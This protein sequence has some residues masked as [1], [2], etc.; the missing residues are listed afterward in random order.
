MNRIRIRRALVRH[1]PILG[2]ALLVAACAG[3][4]GGIKVTDAWAR[5]SPAT[6]SAGAAYLVIEN[7]GTAADALLGASS[8]AAKT[9][10]VHETVDMSSSAPSS[11]GMPAASG[12]MG[13]T[14]PSASGGMDSPM[15]AASGGTSSGPMM[16]MQKVDRV[17]IPA[18]G[19]LELKPGSYHIMLIGLTQDLKVG[20]RIEIT[21]RFEK[22]GEI[23][24]SA[25]VRAS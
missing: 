13:S 17:E 21:L 4:A 25:E 6:A 5:N 20:D 15:P 18:G 10:E 16:G 3:S 8:P 23:T 11:S 1:S 7:P 19:R 2:I 22:A 12:G 9:V 14:A 24:V